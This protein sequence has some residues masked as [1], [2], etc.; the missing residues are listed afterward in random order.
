MFIRSIGRILNWKAALLFMLFNLCGPAVAQQILAGL[1][2]AAMKPIPSVK[3]GEPTVPERPSHRFW[4]RKSSFLFATT[5]AL[6][7]ADFWATRNNLRQ[8]GQELNPVTRAFGSSTAGLATN[9]AGETAAVIGVSYLFHKSG[10]H[11]LE[12]AVTILNI[13]ASAAA[14]TFDVVHH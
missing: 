7:T 2:P 10:H 14:V 5:A 8:G 4:D 6:S 11:K 12:R 3:A 1:Q 13:A 9:F